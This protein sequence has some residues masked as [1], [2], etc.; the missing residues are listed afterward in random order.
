MLIEV[1][2]ADDRVQL[3]DAAAHGFSRHLSRGVWPR[4]RLV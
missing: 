3:V 4:R 1:E 2:A